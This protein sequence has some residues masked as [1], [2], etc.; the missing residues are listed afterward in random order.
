MSLSMPILAEP[1]T[2]QLNNQ[3]RNCYSNKVHIL[4][5]QKNFEKLDTSIETLDFQ[6]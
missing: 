1:L 6:Y 4:K 5:L 2:Q 3:K